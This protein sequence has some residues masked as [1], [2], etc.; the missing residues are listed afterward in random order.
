MPK[1]AIIGAGSAVF[2][3]NI[4]ADILW[5]PALSDSEIVLMDIDP[6]RLD[7][8]LRMARSINETLGTRGVFRATADLE[9]A[10]QGADFVLCTVGVGGCEATRKDLEIPLKFGLKQTIGDTLGVGG[11]F[12]SARSIPVVLELCR[13]MEKLCPKALLMNYANPMAMHML[14]IQRATSVRAVGLCHGV[15]NTAT[16]MRMLVAMR[17]IPEAEIA[18]H[19]QRAYNSPERTAE[20]MRWWVLGRDEHLSYTCAGINHM[21]AFL[22]FESGGRDLYPDLRQLLDLPYFNALE[23]VRFDLLRW[24]GYF[25]TETSTHSAEYLPYFLK[26]DAEIA[27]RSLRVA[28]YLEAV[29]LLHEETEA[30]DQ[31][32]QAGR[33]VIPEKYSLS[34]EY[35]SRIINAVATGEPFVFNGNVH[36]RGGALISNLPGDACVEVPCV[37]DSAGVT[38]TVIGDL[39][40]QVA[41]MIRTNINVQ[42]LAVRGILENSKDYL[43]QAAMLDP[44]TAASLTLAEI[45][46]LMDAMFE[47]HHEILSP[48]L[49][50]RGTCHFE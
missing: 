35:A 20:W 14:A 38:P 48:G 39:P 21:A 31:Q 12:R 49:R 32:L 23:P 37:A 9:E 4:I 2:S 18:A 11:I 25:M 5:H 50:F 41:A 16:T 17:D 45:K 7:I 1:I 40:P 44:N 28:G 29:G 26:N 3:K 13:L 10:L 42:D 43:Y 15:V 34:V 46:K 22:R 30:L 27:T 47:A 6:R 24:L 36:N 8:S 19:F 33:P